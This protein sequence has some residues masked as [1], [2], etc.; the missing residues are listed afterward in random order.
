MD[1]SYKKIIR[2]RQEVD[3]EMKKWIITL[4]ICM[5]LTCSILPSSVAASEPTVRLPNLTQWV[6]M[7]AQYAPYDTWFVMTLSEI[8]AGFDVTN[9]TYPGWCVEVD[10][11]MTLDL[12]LAVGLYSSYNSNMPELFKSANWDKVNYVINNYQNNSRHSVQEVIWKFICNDPLPANDTYAQELYDDANANGG[13]FVPTFGQKIAILADILISGDPSVQRSFFELTLPSEVHLGDLVWNDSNA[14]GIQ[15]DGEPGIQGITVKLLNETNVTVGTTTT[16]SRGYYS[17]SGFPEGTYSLEFVRPSEYYRFSP[18][19]QGTDSTKDSDV[20]TTT[21]RTPQMTAFTPGLFDM[22]WDAG[23]YKVDQP[24]PPGT[25]GDPVPPD[26][27]SP[28]IADGTA[29]EPYTVQFGQ[30]I[31]FNGSRSYDIDGT[32]VSW[33]WDFGDGTHAN[34]AI[35]NHTYANPGKYTVVLTVTDND[36]ATDSYTTIARSRLPPLPPTLNGPASGSQGIDYLLR[37]V[38]T[39]P[40]E[41]DVRYLISWGDGLENTSE[42]F[43]S[44]QSVS[45]MHR[46][47]TWGFFTIEVSAQDTHNASSEVSKMVVAVDVKHVGHLGYLI[48][49]NSDGVFD[50]FYSNST[51][52]QTIAQ[53]QQTGIY[54]IDTNGDGEYDYQFDPTMGSYREYPEA[55]SPT[56]LML[57]AGVAVIILLLLIVGFVIRRRRK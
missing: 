4:G 37:V 42:F 43:I 50:A 12:P 57:L 3:V 17:F 27:N 38:T 23:I 52:S 29:G 51:V 7:R 54:L 33:H 55:L 6:K 49:T 40:D 30:E 41:D 45:F 25:P 5:L 2:E 14:N 47:N 35:V 20:N 46:W 36:D 13:G 44:G 48:D 28:P 39:D 15:D 9:G 1:F 19:N 32:I 26:P 8:P 11:N 22:D 16:D 53:R 21:G 31:L 18:K 34:E 56:Y 24:G 10:V